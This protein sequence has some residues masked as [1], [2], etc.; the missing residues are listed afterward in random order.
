MGDMPPPDYHGTMPMLYGHS[1]IY[2]YPPLRKGSPSR[3]LQ[4]CSNVLL[5]ATFS[6][7]L[8]MTDDDDALGM[9][10]AVLRVRQSRELS[11]Y[12]SYPDSQPKTLVNKYQRTRA[13]YLLVHTT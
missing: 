9:Q 11:A 6:A 7:S 10:Q 1:Y 5:I 4:L 12:C 13:Y 3:S 2:I 8:L